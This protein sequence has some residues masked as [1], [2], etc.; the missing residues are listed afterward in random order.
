[1]L[2]RLQILTEAVQC[3]EDA[4]Q[5][6]SLDQMGPEAAVL[7]EDLQERA[8]MVAS[9]ELDLQHGFDDFRIVIGD[10]TL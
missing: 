7:W 4:A 6:P 1:V 5:G 2:C 8:A 3:E 10:N 9:G